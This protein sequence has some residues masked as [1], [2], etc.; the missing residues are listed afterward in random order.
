MTVPVERVVVRQA[1]FCV[2][3][4]AC[5]PAALTSETQVATASFRCSEVRDSMSLTI[6]DTGSRI[7]A[8]NSDGPTCFA[9]AVGCTEEERGE[10]WVLT[11]VSVVR[12]TCRSHLIY[13]VSVASLVATNVISEELAAVYAVGHLHDGCAL[14]SH[15]T[16]RTRALSR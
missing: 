12:N 16:A 5:L 13:W 6:D 4:V 11:S 9:E 14:L 3:P 2:A 8:R 10:V 15:T 7:G 1:T